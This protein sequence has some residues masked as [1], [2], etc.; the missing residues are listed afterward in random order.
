MISD[1]KSLDPVTVT[2]PDALR[3]SGLGRTKLY[4]LLTKGEIQSVRVG[5]RRL[6]VFASLKALLT[7]KT[8]QLA[9][10]SR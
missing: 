10:E 6:I 9:A 8:A 2:I 5:T 1:G 3:L 4:D 7:P